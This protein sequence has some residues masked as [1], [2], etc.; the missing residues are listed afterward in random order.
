VSNYND[1]D[2]SILLGNGDGTF[3]PAVDYASGS[4]PAQVAIGYL[5]GD[6]HLDLAVVNQFS[7][8]V[9]VLPMET[10]TG[11]LHIRAARSR[12]KTATTKTRIST[13]VHPSCATAWTT[14]A[15]ASLANGKP[16]MMEITT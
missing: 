6:T 11:P 8:D 7:D 4:K 12:R 10:A 9:S 13:R 15:T 1:D 5:D 16:T 3:R 2:V 14:T